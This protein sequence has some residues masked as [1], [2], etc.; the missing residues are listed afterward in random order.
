MTLHTFAATASNL[1]GCNWL[2]CQSLFMRWP[3]FARLNPWAG[4][5][6]KRLE[7]YLETEQHEFR[8]TIE[9]HRKEHDEKERQI[10]LDLFHEHR[11]GS[12]WLEN[13]AMRMSAL[14]L[15]YQRTLIAARIDTR[16]KLGI[17]CPELLSDAELSE[18]DEIMLRSVQVAPQVRRDDYQR[19][20]VAAG[21]PMRRTEQID[22]AA[23][24][25]L[26]ELV[27]REIRKL[28]LA[29]SLGRTVKPAG[30]SLARRLWNDPVWSKVLT[31]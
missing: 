20:A 28:S 30:T 2:N 15:E 16:R 26:E 23:Y 29:R 14:M 3:N 4:R 12:N 6:R 25:D 24:G 17:E 18:L 31:S 19:R 13:R 21:I 7:Q 5:H 9:R 1:S 11:E 27:R 22:A 10:D 8:D